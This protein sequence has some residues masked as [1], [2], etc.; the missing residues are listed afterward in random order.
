[1]YMHVAIQLKYI[2]NRERENS[3]N[4][5]QLATNI[6]FTYI[7]SYLLMIKS[8][9]TFRSRTM[10]EVILLSQTL[11]PFRG[12]LRIEHDGKN[13]SIDTIKLVI[14]IKLT[15]LLKNTTFLCHTIKDL[16]TLFCSVHQSVSRNSTSSVS[17]F[18]KN[19]TGTLARIISGVSPS[20]IF[21]LVLNFDFHERCLRPIS[22]N[23]SC[24]A[25]RSSTNIGRWNSSCTFN[26]SINF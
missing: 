4:Q 13:V 20:R 23:A 24:C 26:V 25:L 8:S 6:V 22:F 18:S 10:G 7:C 14:K 3:D 16:Q 9:I 15:N 1:M 21:S 19:L 2:T 17:Y 12:R 11:Y 5:Q